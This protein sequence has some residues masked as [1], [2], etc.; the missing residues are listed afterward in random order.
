MLL[1]ENAIIDLGE[2]YVKQSYRNRYNIYSASGKQ[3][4]TI[5]VSKPDGNHTAV[6]RIMISNHEPWQRIH[7]RTIEAAYQNSPFF[8]H[9]MDDIKDLLNNRAKTISEYN[10]ICFKGLCELLELPVAHSYTE[11]Y[12]EDDSI[13]LRNKITPKRET[14]VSEFLSKHP[15]HQ[16]FEDKHGYIKDL[17]L[18]D[19]LF[20]MGPQGSSF[21]TKTAEIYRNASAG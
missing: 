11:K 21:I 19:I 4:M 12:Y 10:I 2:N 7:W 20:N 13:D 8:I 18:L 17:S 1:A 16:V 5:P 3:A 15:Y 14:S 9:Y 6:H